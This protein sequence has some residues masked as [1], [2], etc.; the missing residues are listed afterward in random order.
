VRPRENPGSACEKRAPPYFGMGPR[1]V[2]P[3]LGLSPL[4]CSSQSSDLDLDLMTFI[5]ELHE[6]SLKMY[7]SKGVFQINPQS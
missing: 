4:V 5:Y 1:M 2:N 7:T 3:A 6:Y